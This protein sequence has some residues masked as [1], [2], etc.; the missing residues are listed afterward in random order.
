MLS[1]K[2][3]ITLSGFYSKRP[4]I[5]HLRETDDEKI[6]YKTR[7]PSTLSSDVV[8]DVTF[9]KYSANNKIV[10]SSTFHIF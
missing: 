9:S 5:S 3:V 6:S 1:L 7:A 8:V 10:I 4:I 2:V